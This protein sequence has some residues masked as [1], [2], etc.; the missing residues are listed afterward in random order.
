MHIH[1]RLYY[2]NL[3]L[4][5]AFTPWESTATVT[6]NNVTFNTTG[7]LG[8][9]GESVPIFNGTSSYATA[10]IIPEKHAELQATDSISF[11]GWFYIGSITTTQVLFHSGNSL[12]SGI[13]LEVINSDLRCVI[14]TYDSSHDDCTNV[15]TIGWHHLFVT[16]TTSRRR[17]YLD[18]EIINETNSTYSFSTLPDTQYIGAFSGTSNFFKGRLQMFYYTASC[19]STRTIKALAEGPACIIP[20]YNL[21]LNEGLRDYSNNS[22]DPVVQGSLT[23][24][25][26][27]P[28]CASAVTFSGSAAKYIALGGFV[29]YTQTGYTLSIRFKTTKADTA[30]VLLDNA[31]QSNNG[32]RLL[33]G[34]NNCVKVAHGNGT[35]NINL[36]GPEIQTNTWYMLTATWDGASIKLYLNGVLE[37]QI[38]MTQP[39]TNSTVADELVVGRSSYQYTNSSYQYAYPLYGSV[40]DVRVYCTALSAQRIWEL[41]NIPIQI[42][43]SG[44][45]WGYQ[46]IKNASSTSFDHRGILTTGTFTNTSDNSNLVS[47]YN[48]AVQA[49]YFDYM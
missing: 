27:S 32:M 26:S 45:I 29:N 39:V 1:K 24:D 9:V 30:Q 5:P 28:R 6:P 16:C 49:K 44:I 35:E 13:V 15:L 18:G 41:Y 7:T 40:I 25:T 20:L 3:A 17:I 43:D 47:I 38:A 34:S 14:N 48:T 42:D 11:G 31:K 8:K 36:D 12:T 4:G 37:A 22:R 23:L 33:I 46:L 21:D 10:V 19:V 2:L